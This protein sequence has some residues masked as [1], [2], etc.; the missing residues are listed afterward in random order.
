MKEFPSATHPV[1]QSEMDTP[2]TGNDSFMSS[3]P[4]LQES[5]KN[6]SMFTTRFQVAMKA[7]RVW[8]HFDGSAMRPEPLMPPPIVPDDATNIAQVAQAIA[9][10]A[11]HQQAAAADAAQDQDLQQRQRT[12]DTG[13]AV[14]KHY[15]FT[16]IPDTDVT[17]IERFD[18][19]SQMWSALTATHRSRSMYAQ[20]TMRSDYL[21]MKCPQGSTIPDWMN[22]IRTKRRELAEANIVL[23]QY[24]HLSAFIQSLPGGLSGYANAQLDHHRMATQAQALASGVPLTPEQLE[25]A[26]QID[27]EFLMMMVEQEA[28]RRKSER[29]S[30]NPPTDKGKGKT[31][32]EVLS[33]ESSEKRKETRTCY[34]CDKKGHLARNCRKPKKESKGNANAVGSDPNFRSDPK[35]ASKDS[36]NVVAYWD[37]SD[38]CVMAAVETIDE[39]NPNAPPDLPL[40]RAG[41][42][43]D[44]DDICASV[45]SPGKRLG[46]LDSGCT[47]HISCYK[48]DFTSFRPIH[49]KP[50]TAANGDVFYATGEGELAIVLQGRPVTLRNVLY[51][52]KVPYTLI[53]V[54]SLDQ[55]GFSVSL[56]SGCAIIRDTHNSPV[57]EI[58][59][60]S[61]GL[62]RISYSA[63]EQV[64]AVTVP[65]MTLVELHEHLGHLHF[66]AC[67]TMVRA[68]KVKGLSVDIPKVM[69]T[70]ESC[71]H[72][73][74]TR[75]PIAR[76]REGERSTAFG[77]LVFA[78]VWGPAKVISG[79]GH[80]YYVLF[81]D[82]HTR[83]AF[84]FFVGKKS[85]TFGAYKQFDALVETRYSKHVKV[86]HSDRG[87][88]FTSD[89]FK[90]YLKKRGT[91]QRL[92]TH[93]TPQH[94]G[95][96]E[97]RNRTTMEAVR[98][99]LHRARL[100]QRF[101][102]E[103]A[104][105]AVWL[106]N[107]T[108]TRVLEGKSPLE[109]MEG[110]LLDV[111]SVLPFGAKVWVHA[112]NVPKTMIRANP[113]VY[114]GLDEF[115]GAISNG[116][117]I[118][119]PKTKRIHIERN[120]MLASP[121][122]G[123]DQSDCGF[124]QSDAQS[125]EPDTSSDRVTR[126]DASATPAPAQPDGSTTPAPP[127]DKRIE[128]RNFE[129]EYSNNEGTEARHDF[130]TTIW[131]ED[132]E[133]HREVRERVRRARKASSLIRTLLEQGAPLPQGTQ[134]NADES[135][136]VNAESDL[137]DF[138]M[139]VN[140]TDGQ[141]TEPNSFAQVNRMPPPER[142]LW[143][144]AMKEE[145]DSLTGAGTWA[146]EDVPSDA[147]VVGCRWVF[148][149][150][151]DAAG[152]PVRYKARLVAQGFSQVPGVDYFDTYA[153]VGKLTSIRV[154]LAYA[155]YH[156]W[157]LEQID[158]KSAYLNGDFEAGEVIWMRPPPGFGNLFKGVRAL[159]L[160]RP[161][162]GLKQSGRRWYEKFVWIFKQ[163]GYTVS[164]VDPGIFYLK[165]PDGLTIVII[166]VD[167]CT[168]GASNKKLISD[169][170][171]GVQRYVEIT[172]LGELHWLLGIEVRRSRELKTLSISQS[173][174][175]DS[176]IARFNLEDLKPAVTPLDPN[177]QLTTDM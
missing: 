163:L 173:A 73:K 175:I 67:E 7:K 116:A 141:E 65:R 167:D 25:S 103:A 129:G 34:N 171:S 36:A 11:Q 63:P 160:L 6:W 54:G 85:E 62:Y 100:P 142:D 176:I 64:C 79:Q 128:T 59:L 69:P 174:Y 110:K 1:S 132:S 106:Q 37:D 94:N 42:D 71:I 58:P 146:M 113:A 15:L 144:A 82:D 117:R 23:S 60:S 24:D 43:D 39:G 111:Q 38:D 114:L 22:A 136:Y 86:L 159:K 10:N 78:D 104:R 72:G 5:G 55:A 87:G 17:K 18:R 12:F 109:V 51:A 21:T 40:P 124:D 133:T 90:G 177:V 9:L 101:W 140:A 83:M 102:A 115:P 52:Q 137:E 131:G 168:I 156:D 166:H 107:R 154:L 139:A 152:K 46:I 26:F 75:A 172:D 135:A 28:E 130:D 143:M 158:V 89:E 127:P 161:I 32:D 33:A 84:I 148:K 2:N 48:E 97:R 98:T 80:R 120:F 49:P 76:M 121:D 169:F 66:K 134:T 162:Y 126:P 53:S 155:A 45:H 123:S 8:T 68:G 145:L 95:V 30:R 44:D 150:K 157:E 164:R 105:H 170:K 125:G 4:K 50:L 47:R 19:V 108:P 16:R 99:M 27:I 3:V 31:K 147:N 77:D 14:A 29:A 81:I 70:C 88:E 149:I 119:Y 151:R 93:D 153:P 20:A 61:R 165:S 112:P 74:L 96:V 41:G 122:C 35:G 92:T 118:Y 138:V 56:G 91:Q 13:E 57:G